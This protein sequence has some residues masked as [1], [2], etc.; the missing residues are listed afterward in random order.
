VAQFTPRQTREPLTNQSGLALVES[1]LTRA[2]METPPNH[3]PTPQRAGIYHDQL[4]DCPFYAGA[5][6]SGKT[7]L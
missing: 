7:G 5:I 2:S 3:L 1:L 6:G 4:R